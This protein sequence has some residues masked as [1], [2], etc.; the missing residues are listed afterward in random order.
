MGGKA[1]GKQGVGAVDRR[2]G[3]AVGKRQTDAE[4]DLVIRIREEPAR[5]ARWVRQFGVVSALGR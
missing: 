4:A 1:E 5:G 2:D 3:F